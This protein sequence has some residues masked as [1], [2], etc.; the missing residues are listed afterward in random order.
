MKEK[1]ET[2]GKKKENILRMTSAM[3]SAAR[4]ELRCMGDVRDG[5]DTCEDVKR[6]DFVGRARDFLTYLVLFW[7]DQRHRQA[8][9]FRRRTSVYTIISVA[10]EPD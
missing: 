6:R 4:H 10:A 7:Q 9:S 5:R 1:R 2:R 3:M 8:T